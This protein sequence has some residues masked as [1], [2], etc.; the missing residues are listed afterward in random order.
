MARIALTTEELRGASTNFSTKAGELREL[1]NYLRQQVNSL[2][3]T[4]DGAAQN[5]F[6]VTFD[7][8]AKNMDQIPEAI[9]NIGNQLSAVATTME[10]TDNEL[11]NALRGN[12]WSLFV[13][14]P[15]PLCIGKAAIRTR[16]RHPP[17][18]TRRQIC[19]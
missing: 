18:W 12:G 14:V 15:Q 10:N 6:F 1:L 19:V 7:E 17:I 3:S 2:E 13:S 9:E 4:W 8:I 5:Q 16:R 11:A